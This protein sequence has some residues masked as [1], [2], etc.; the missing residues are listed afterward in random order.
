MPEIMSKFIQLH[1]F[2]RNKNSFEFLALKRA[3]DLMVYPSIWQV[4]TGTIEKAETAVETALREIYEETNLEPIRLWNI[5]TLTS[6]YDHKTD[7]VHLSPV[8]AAEVDYSSEVKLSC[9]HQKFKWLEFNAIVD[10]LL[11]PSHKEATKVLMESIIRCKTN[12][13]EIKM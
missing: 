2:R 6:F 13:F 7:I 10:I 5:P 1:V 12:E 8:F 9:E 3:D 4:I 11:L